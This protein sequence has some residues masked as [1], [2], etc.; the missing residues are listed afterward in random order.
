LLGSWYDSA[1]EHK[2]QWGHEKTTILGKEVSCGQIQVTPVTE[3][4]K[5]LKYMLKHLNS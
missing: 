5:R 3:A 4:F 2:I 1:I